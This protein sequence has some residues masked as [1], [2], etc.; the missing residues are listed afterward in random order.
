MVTRS[1]VAFV[2]LG[3]NLGDR[4][5]NMIEAI[6][7][8]D[9]PPGQRVTDVSSLYETEPVDGPATQPRYLNAAIRVIT[10]HS[11]SEL[12]DAASEIET[13]LGRIRTVPN[14]PRTIDVDILLYDDLAMSE[15]S[16]TIPHARM[17]Q[18]AFVMVPLCDIAPTVRHPILG[19]TIG[20]VATEFRDADGITRV[21]EASWFRPPTE[22]QQVETGGAECPKV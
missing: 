13:A 14:G 8:L 11:P 15:T 1:A 7:R 21:E 10:S 4:R 6:V 20:D 5:A 9:A 16:L 18:R 2:A 22:N 17:H 19:R 12:L 3:S